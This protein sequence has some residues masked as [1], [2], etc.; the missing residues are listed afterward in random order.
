[1][2]SPLSFTGPQPRGFLDGF[3]KLSPGLPWWLTGEES[4]CQC[5]GHGFD[6][7]SGKIPHAQEQLSLCTA[8]AEAHG[9]GAHALQHE[10]PLQREAHAPQ[11][12]VPRLLHLEKA[13]VQQPRPSA[14]K[15]KI[16]RRILLYERKPMLPELHKLRLTSLSITLTL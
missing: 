6:P 8:T 15:S 4:T 5:R 9:P 13:H 11:Q 2:A 16:K 12:R 1:M 14:A 10:K 3:S 7:W